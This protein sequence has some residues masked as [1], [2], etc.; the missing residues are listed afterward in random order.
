M[1]A[2]EKELWAKVINDARWYDGTPE[3]LEQLTEHF[4]RQGIKV[5]KSEI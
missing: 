4:N 3:M 5:K 2:Q 1:T